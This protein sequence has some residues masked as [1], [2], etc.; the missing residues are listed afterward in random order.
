MKKHELK[1]NLIISG[2][3]FPEPVQVMM[4]HDMGNLVKVIGKGLR[5]DKFYDPI[6]D[7]NQL[8]TIT[9]SPEKEPFDGDP[10]RFRLGIEG[11]RLGLAYEYD[12]YF[13]LSIAR[14]D[15]LLH[16]LEA[17]YDYFLKLPRI[18]FLLAD[19]PGAGKTIMAGLLIKELKI[20]GLAQRTLIVTP[21]NLSFQWKREL[22]DK[23]RENFEVIRGEVLRANY[24]SN[25]WQ[26]KNQVITSVSWVSRIDDAKESLLRS[27]WDLIIV[28]EAHKMSAYSADKKTLAYQ[29]G[30][31]LSVMTDHYLLMTATP[32]K[33]SPENF[34]L[35]LSLLDKDVYGDVKSLEEAM[36][37]HDAPFYLRRVKEALVSFPDPE[38]GKVKTLFTR[39]TVKTSEFAIGADEN[40]YAVQ[41]ISLRIM[42]RPLVVPLRASALL[43]RLLLLTRRDAPDM[44]NITAVPPREGPIR[45]DLGIHQYFNEYIE[46]GNDFEILKLVVANLAQLG[47]ALLRIGHLDEFFPHGVD[48][49]ILKLVYTCLTRIE[50]GNLRLNGFFGWRSGAEIPVSSPFPRHGC[51][52]CHQIHLL[53]F[54][55]NTDIEQ[56]GLDRLHEGDEFRC[57]GKRIQPRFTFKAVWI[58]CLG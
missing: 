4:T 40:R 15:P 26:E 5:T 1:A 16:Q 47:V 27:H 38:T 34:C 49:V 51:N 33:G 55:F 31:S 14:I 30:E 41:R 23:F 46:E 48:R 58:T 39:R 6:L 2:P 44:A 50:G 53:Q 17:V 52:G 20:R 3:I 57:P 43:T 11:L 37:R 28:D 9:A 7:A 32:H 8:D 29:L 45:H 36:A 25:P 42:L 12:P 56:L 10:V 13:S 54:Q 18:R 35:F 21:A 22:I 19:D 24:G